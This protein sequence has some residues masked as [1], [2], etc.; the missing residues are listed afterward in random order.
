MIRITEN[1]ALGEA[2]IEER[3]ILAGGPGGQNVNKVATAVQLRFDAARSP[4]LTPEV[5]ARLKTLCGRRMTKDGI[6]VITARRYRMQERNRE[7]ALGRLVALIAQAATPPVPRR[8]R[9]PS[10]GAKKRR[11][12]AKRHRARLKLNRAPVTRDD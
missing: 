12:E 5:L 10:L 6:V 4:A 2:E 1:I 3:F 7:D 8:K 9:R 11:M